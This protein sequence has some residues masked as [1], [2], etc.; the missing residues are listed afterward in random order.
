M[1]DYADLPGA[2]MRYETEGTGDQHQRDV[3]RPTCGPRRLTGIVVIGANFR[4][5][6]ECFAE[7]GM[8]D[9]LTP[10]SDDLAFFRETYEAVTPDGPTSGDDDLMTL[11]Q[12]TLVDRLILEHL[13]QKTTETVMPV[14]RAGRG[15]GMR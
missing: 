4:P 11:E 2:R 10:D 6:P 15:R 5:A 3:G 8:L 13:A 7:P 14:R 12:P 1:G 9:A